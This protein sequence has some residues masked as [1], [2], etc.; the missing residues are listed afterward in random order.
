MSVSSPADEEQ[1]F[2]APD[3]LDDD[4]GAPKDSP[5]PMPVIGIS[6]SEVPAARKTPSST[7]KASPQPVVEPVLV[8]RVPEPEVARNSTPLSSSEEIEVVEAADL[9]EQ[10]SS[11]SE[12]SNISEGVTALP[13]PEIHVCFSCKMVYQKSGYR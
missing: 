2:D 13:F 6:N 10:D 12:K 8:P 5:L 9:P 4:T 3:H 7:P 1:F 11:Q